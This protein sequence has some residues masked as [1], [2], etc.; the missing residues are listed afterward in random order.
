MSRERVTGP[1][2]KAEQHV[3][4]DG[5]RPDPARSL[6]EG[7][8]P[9][10]Q[11][12]R[13]LGNRNVARL[14]E[15]KRLT[16]EGTIRGTTA[17]T[18]ARAPGNGGEQRSDER[19][20][21]AAKVA[22]AAIS[23][24]HALP[25][26]LAGRLEQS[27]GADLSG[28]RV[29]TAAASAEAAA[30]LGASAYTS[31]QDIHFGAG[32]YDPSSMEGQRL[33][34]HEVTHTVQQQG[35]GSS[36]QPD[37]EVSQPDDPHEVQAEAFAQAFIAGGT[38]PVTR[39]L[40]NS[41][42][43]V[44]RDPDFK[45]KFGGDV[46]SL[47][48]E[49][50]NAEIKLK[51]TVKN[52]RT[53]PAGT[54]LVWWW[55]TAGVDGVEKGTISPAT[56]PDATF[57]A[58]AKKP[59]PS[60]ASTELPANLEVTEPGTEAVV[61]PVTPPLEVS[62]LEPEYKIEQKVVPGAQGGGSAD[63]LKP[64]DVLEFHVT[65]ENMDK[66][67]DFGNAGD[68]RWLL[69]QKGLFLPELEGVKITD[70]T[71]F[72]SRPHRWEGDTL[73]YSVYCH[74]AGTAKYKLDFNVPGT[75]PV[76]K[77]FDLKSEA[78]L[79]FFLERCNAATNRHRALVATFDAYLQQGFLNYKA[80]YDAAEAAF[81]E[82]AERQRLTKEILLGILFAGLGGAA[83]GY[84]G[85][86]VKATAGQKHFGK[87]ANAALKEAAIGAITDAPKDIAK[88]T[89]RLGRK[90]GEGGGGTA[91]SPDDATPD[92][93][94]GGGKS[95]VAGSVEPLNWYATVQKAKS[96]EESKIATT[97]QLWQTKTIDAIARGSTETVDFDPVNA[98]TEIT[99]LE[100]ETVTELGTPPSP[101]EYEKNMWEAWIEKYAYT[102]E[103][104]VG[105]YQFGYRV[106]DNVGKELREEME[107]VAKVL[108]EK[109]IESKWLTDALNEA[110]RIAEEKAKAS[111]KW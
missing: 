57:N 111:Q 51:A 53:A 15:A 5:S 49:N 24:G 55:G 10:P 88:Y 100:G 96:V 54:S 28:T 12:Q 26:G 62:V 18:E 6:H 95:G 64:S 99:K 94:G 83:G 38:S 1:P 106:S 80:G 8:T 13:M 87:I 73:V 52:A 25:P 37:L 59:T 27:L 108:A 3:A 41:A 65:F 77:E 14:I 17:G 85:G 78:S 92:S 110:E 20:D 61:H 46:G 22:S 60:G 36:I 63:A 43:G 34:A 102:L 67:V 101:A 93:G 30:A 35:A 91:P 40:T 107:R 19:S 98:I 105:C 82:Y 29:H 56:G 11:L 44:S 2:A 109:G 68:F 47:A 4:S 21:L 39:M 69:T 16:R 86:L 9:I 71:P 23:S 66:P 90:L 7:L 81:K 103:Q 31:G 48:V 58:K 74:H 75:K 45:P 97:L 32:K 72:Q 84:V 33:I 42:V 50:L 89:V 104:K 79:A 70:D 76:T